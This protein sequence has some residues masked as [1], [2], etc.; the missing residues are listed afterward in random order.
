MNKNNKGLALSGSKGFT[1]IELLVVI[2]IIGILASLVLVALGNARSKANDA[3]IKSNIS[4]LRTLAE[5]VYDNN[6]SSYGTVGAC[7]NSDVGA[8][9][10]NCKG[11]ETSVLSLRADTTT[12]GGSVTSTSAAGAYCVQ[13]VLKSTTDRF[14]ADSTGVA[15]VVSA[16]CTVA[17]ACP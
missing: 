3:R 10:A 1:L 8:T 2:A 7:F 14:C 11:A 17:N 4:Q 13:S 15:K 9:A 6:S 16:A 5:Q 12:A